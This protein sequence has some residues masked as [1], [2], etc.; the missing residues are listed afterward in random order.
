MYWSPG[1]YSQYPVVYEGLDGHL[2]KR[3]YVFTWFRSIMYVFIRFRSIMA[4]VWFHSILALV[5][6]ANI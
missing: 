2:D 1:Y 6:L 4:V 3:L 5:L